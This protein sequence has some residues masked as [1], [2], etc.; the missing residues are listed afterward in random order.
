M[1]IEI[2]ICLFQ[3]FLA[4]RAARLNHEEF[5]L[6]TDFDLIKTEELSLTA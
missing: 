6:S 4:Q 2:D 1:P 3:N 5:Q